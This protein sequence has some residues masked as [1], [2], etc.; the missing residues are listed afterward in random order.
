MITTRLV[1]LGAGVALWA[2][3]PPVSSPTPA[4]HPAVAPAPSAERPKPP[5]TAAT[6]AQ[7]LAQA[8]ALT[9]AGRLM[10]CGP[11]RPPLLIDLAAGTMTDL[12][13]VD[14]PYYEGGNSPGTAELRAC[15]LRFD[16]T[17]PLALV[18]HNT[19]HLVLWDLDKRRPAG[20]FQERWH[21]RALAFSPTGS[22]ALMATSAPLLF[23]WDIERRALIHVWKPAG[24][25]QT[26]AFSPD[27]KRAWVGTEGQSELWD[28]ETYRP[29]RSFDRSA[30]DHVAFVPDGARGLWERNRSLWLWDLDQDRPPRILSGAPGSA[31]SFRFSPDGTTLALAAYGSVNLWDLAQRGRR[32]VLSSATTSGW[33]YSVDVS[34]DN[35]QALVGT[36]YQDKMELWDLRTGRSVAT[37]PH[38]K[39]VEFV[40]FL[41]GDTRAVTLSGSA[42]V[43]LW[44]LP[45]R[46]A[47]SSFR[48]PRYTDALG[49]SPDGRRLAT[50]TFAPTV[51]LR[52]V[53]TGKVDQVLTSH[54]GAIT[55]VRF[56][57]DGTRALT[58][59]TDGVVRVW[60]PDPMKL[61]HVMPAHRGPIRC[62]ALD[63]AGRWALSG[64]SAKAE[65][66]LWNLEQGQLAQT[67]SHAS[68]EVVTAVFHP[69][70]HRA[71]TAMSDASLVEWDLSTGKP[72]LTLRGAGSPV[73]ALAI[74]PDGSRALSGHED[75]ALRIWS[76]SSGKLLATRPGAGVAI[77]ALT[78][79]ARGELALSAA[80]DGTLRLWRLD[81]AYAVTI[82][83]A[84]P[85]WAAFADDGT[86]MGSERA[87]ALFHRVWGTP[88]SPTREQAPI[89]PRP[90][91]IRKGLGLVPD[92]Q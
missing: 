4:A 12:T 50:T 76:L 79:A 15:G 25:P 32:R 16:G 85:Q 20:R 21:V 48:T 13:T 54:T 43:T 86:Y 92:R 80:D 53:E 34:S 62:L 58:G 55:H 70:A 33:V 83:T 72:R 64:S 30:L 44:D 63:R 61:Q 73:S 89:G 78:I 17:R 67:L 42:Q 28:L 14:G 84:G 75:G 41:P 82:T 23:H 77:R 36:G 66:K 46:R 69:T 90:E 24:Y 51:T 74:H 38:K 49:L 31:K 19:P 40:R 45:T 56:A 57:A 60:S 27:G 71:L 22:E 9:A 39:F 5:F 68:G 35:R 1:A 2:C 3:G 87:S 37:Y 88:E 47:L 29:L 81:N 91:E 7:P 18:Q 26:I 10:A 59:G 11:G 52:D 6:E 8:V 65:L